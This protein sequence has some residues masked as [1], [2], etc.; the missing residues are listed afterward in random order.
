MV[1]VAEN[2]D[3]SKEVWCGVVRRG[4]EGNPGTA[5]CVVLTCPAFVGDGG[6]GGG[7]KGGCSRLTINGQLASVLIQC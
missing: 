3:A 1:N 7:A 5:V 6:G 4:K 2:S